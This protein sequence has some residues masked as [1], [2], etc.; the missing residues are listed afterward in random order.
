MHFNGEKQKVRVGG[1]KEEAR[2]RGH[3]RMTD[4]VV[5]RRSRRVDGVARVK[6]MKMVVNIRRRL[7]VDDDLREGGRGN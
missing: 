1:E 2:K 3:A 7:N 4:L 6:K 5:C